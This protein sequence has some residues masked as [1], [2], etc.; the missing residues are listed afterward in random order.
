MSA[1][2]SLTVVSTR[3]LLLATPDRASL[4]AFN[5]MHV[6]TVVKIAKRCA[7]AMVMPA[8]ASARK[9]TNGKGFMTVECRATGHLM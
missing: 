7:A 3:V 2:G 1:G 8:S 4:V 6:A 9:A 5:K